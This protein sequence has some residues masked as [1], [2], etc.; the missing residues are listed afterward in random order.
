[1]SLSCG[2]RFLMEPQRSIAFGAIGA[3]YMSIGTELEH[4]ARMYEIHNLTDVPL[5]FSLDGLVD[6]FILPASSYKIVDIVSNNT[7]NTNGWYIGNG[8]SFY[9]KQIGAGAPGSG[10]VYLSIAYGE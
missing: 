8:T 10:S 5:Q 9:V 1:M 6:H 7:G 3:V 4:P 2:I